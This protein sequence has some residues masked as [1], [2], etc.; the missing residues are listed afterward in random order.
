MVEETWAPVTVPDFED[1]YEVSDLGHVRRGPTGR[2][3]K[4]GLHPKGYHG[5]VLSGR[6]KRASVLIHKLVL[7][8][9]V[10]PRPDGLE[11]RHLDG[12]PTNN[13]LSNLIWG[14]SSEN[15]LDKRRHGTSQQGARNAMNKLT[16]EQV[17]EII[18]RY[19]NGESQRALAVTFGIRQ[20]QVSRIVTGQRW[21]H[22]EATVTG[23]S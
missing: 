23:S 7:E 18:S 5:V 6:G 9:F 17:R 15:E 14:T 2:I 10:S 1:L 21:G 12:D 11:A 19:A 8:A 13:R 16:E 4:P 22:L 3:L 20:P